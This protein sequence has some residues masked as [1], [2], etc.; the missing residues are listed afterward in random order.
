MAKTETS[1]PRVPAV[2]T[3]SETEEAAFENAWKVS[4]NLH[5]IADR[6][7]L[8]LLRGEVSPVLA[9]VHKV[10]LDLAT[11]SV[12]IKPYAK[13]ARSLVRYVAVREAHDREGYSWDEAP[14]RAAEL[15]RGQPAEA[16]RDWM[17]EEYCKV[18]KAL[19]DAGA[20]RDDDDPGYRWIDLPDKS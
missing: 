13:Q 12:D 8:G 1:M 16:G 7:A 15:L 11:A 9:W 20:V 3:V 2:P 17:W 5:V 10:L 6:L 4:G 19:R 18:R 14:D